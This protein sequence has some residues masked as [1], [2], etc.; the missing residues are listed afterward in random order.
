V[1]ANDQPA[2]LDTGSSASFAIPDF[3]D[4]APLASALRSQSDTFK[5]A[6][7][8]FLQCTATLFHV[9]SQEQVNE[10]LDSFLHI[11]EPVSLST[12]CEACSIAAVGSRYSRSAIPAE[13]GGYYFNVSKLL[14]DDCIEKSPLKAIKV[15]ALL[16]MCNIVNK[17]TVA[18]AYVELGLAIARLQGLFAQDRPLALDVETWIDSKKVFRSLVLC[19]G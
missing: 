17:S 1:T 4:P 18:F 6:F 14:L 12:L 5:H 16:A 10:V 9:Y 19:R 15:C 13:R 11:K 8:V 2:L 7:S 3:S